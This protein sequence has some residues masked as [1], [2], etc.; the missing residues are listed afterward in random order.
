MKFDGEEIR[1]HKGRFRI[2]GGAPL[3]GEL[4]IAGESTELQLHSEEEI[5]VPIDPELCITGELF[6]LQQVSLH[7]CIFLGRRSGRNQ[8]SCF[9]SVSIFPH[10]VFVGDYEI[11]PGDFVGSV[12]VEFEDI[13][14]LFYDFDAFGSAGNPLQHLKKI[15]QDSSLPRPIPLGPDPQ[16]VY[17]AGKRV[18]LDEETP[19][20]KVRV[21]HCPDYGIGGPNGIRLDNRILLTFSP[22]KKVGFSEVLESFYR[23]QSFI[24]V[25]VGRPQNHKQMSLSALDDPEAWPLSV[26]ISLLPN[27]ESRA[28]SE[29]PHVSDML[30][31]PIGNLDEFVSL[32]NKW[33]SLDP[34]MRDSR[35]RFKS[36]VFD[37]RYSVDR[38]VAAANMFDILPDFAIPP[39]E[40]LPAE[41]KRAQEKSRS[42][43]SKL[44]P[45]DE[46]NSILGALGRIGGTTLKKKAIHRA[47]L[48]RS[49]STYPFY[50]LEVVLTEAINL[51]NHYVHGSPLRADYGPNTG[52]LSFL[53]DSLEFVFGVSDLITCGW[54][55]QAYMCSSSVGRHP[56]GRYKSNFIERVGR[57]QKLLGEEKWSNLIEQYD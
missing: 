30:A 21:A 49:N 56:F 28:D 1:R 20:G 16:L 2:A 32:L 47:K 27:Q 48:L 26:Y 29:S 31:D 41:M 3:F 38:L 51:R 4:I 33:L 15:S 8:D 40:E 5:E 18:L 34:L 11:C 54:D 42:L 55:F 57:F 37:T 35:C 17:F 44:P 45:S 53:T 43:F 39:K 24:E 13:S 9:H 36:C 46:R 10:F 50:G 19:L 6:D 25:L 7:K 12:T 22:G 23:I 14:T 52:A